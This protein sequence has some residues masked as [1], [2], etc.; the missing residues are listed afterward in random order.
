MPVIFYSDSIITARGQPDHSYPH[1]D[2]LLG[3]I[4]LEGLLFFFGCPALAGNRPF[5]RPVL[6][7]PL[8]GSLLKRP[9]QQQFLRRLTEGG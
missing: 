7:E 8:P 6:L 1:T 4:E 5:T 9:S 3:H 2:L